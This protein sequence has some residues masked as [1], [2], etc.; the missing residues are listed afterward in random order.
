MLWSRD[1]SRCLSKECNGPGIEMAKH[2]AQ[3]IVARRGHHEVDS[4]RGQLDGH[5]HSSFDLQL[6]AHDD[7]DMLPDLD[8]K[9][10]VCR[11]AAATSADRQWFTALSSSQMILK[12]Q[13]HTTLKHLKNSISAERLDAKKRKTLHGEKSWWSAFR[14]RR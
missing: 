1:E 3:L 9:A 12:R 14:G 5:E 8:Q 10:S 6:R 2:S 13:A 11:P 4:G 7:T